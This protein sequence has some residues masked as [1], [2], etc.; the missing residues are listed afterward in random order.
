[1]T[2]NGAVPKRLPEVGAAARRGGGPPWMTAGM[3]AEKSMTFGPSARRLLAR[4]RPERTMVLGVLA[5]AMISVTLAVLGPK[6]LGHATNIIFAGALGKGL[7]ANVSLQQAVDTAR[8]HGDGEPGQPGALR[9]W[10]HTRGIGLRT[11]PL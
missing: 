9:R 11:A 4:L 5:L 2:T 6:I 1:M 10:L 7:P 8:A 3:P